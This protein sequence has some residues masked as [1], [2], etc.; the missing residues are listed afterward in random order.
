MMNYGWRI[1]FLAVS[2]YDMMMILEVTPSQNQ[3]IAFP[4]YMCMI[5]R[6]EIRK[7]KEREQLKQSTNSVPFFTKLDRDNGMTLA[8]VAGTAWPDRLQKTM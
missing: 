8:R 2:L 5:F 3:S 1:E 4:G 6:L 7:S